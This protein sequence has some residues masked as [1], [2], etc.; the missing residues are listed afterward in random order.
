MKLNEW[1]AMSYAL[2]PA[3]PDREGP[4]W[5]KGELN[6]SYHRRWFVL[7]G[8]LL[9]YFERR[10]DREPQGLILLEGCSVEVCE[11]SA[12]GFAF[13]LVFQRAPG[14]RLY[15]L[16][17]EDLA[18]QEGWIRALT[19][20]S[21]GY[22]R[23]LV[24]DLE[25]QFEEL[26]RAGAG[27]RPQRNTVLGV[28][29]EP[30]SPTGSTDPRAAKCQSMVA[31]PTPSPPGKSIRRSPKLWPKRQHACPAA[32]PGDAQG[33]AVPAPEDFL[34]LHMRYRVA[35][36]QARRDWRQRWAGD[37]QTEPA[38]GPLIDLS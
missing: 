11:S 13:A 2:G 1:A 10:A 24:R 22:I 33:V 27:P 20:A 36:E 18:G 23:M 15:K 38:I 12:E 35:V 25:G 31:L 5:K 32:Q 17:A 7:R 16:L 19:H 29:P 28:F 9:F 21:L 26:Y 6:P 30:P 34:T 14:M 3:S 37:L 8:N 4:L